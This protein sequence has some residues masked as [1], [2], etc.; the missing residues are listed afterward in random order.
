MQVADC[1]VNCELES[2]E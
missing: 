1:L 2:S